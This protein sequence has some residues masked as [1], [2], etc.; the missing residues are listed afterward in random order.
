LGS[1]PPH[2]SRSPALASAR[3]V[4]LHFSF[5]QICGLTIASTSLDKLSP[6]VIATTGCL[7][8]LIEND[9]GMAALARWS[10]RHL[11]KG[12]SKYVCIDTDAEHSFPPRTPVSLSVC[13]F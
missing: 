10:K 2:R 4:F 11:K 8:I 5:V 1:F 6:A 3:D 9:A 12:R 13:P 7:Y